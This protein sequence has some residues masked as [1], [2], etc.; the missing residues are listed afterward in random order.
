M[1]QG[2]S[3]MSFYLKWVLIA[4][5]GIGLTACHGGWN[6]QIETVEAI[7]KDKK[8]EEPKPKAVAKDSLQIDS[9]R[10]YE[11]FEGTEAT[12]SFSGRSAF[13]DSK[14][15]MEILNL[16]ERLPGATQEFE[17]GEL[18]IGDVAQE[19]PRTGQITIK[20]TPDDGFVKEQLERRITM[21]VELRATVDGLAIYRTEQEFM[22][23]IR[24]VTE[25]PE[26][27]E[28]KGLEKPLR[29]G[30]ARQFQVVVRD[31][32]SLNG[33]GT[34]VAP[35]LKIIDK[36]NNYRAA[37]HL[38]YKDTSV[39]PEQD[40]QDPSIW[41]IGL[42]VN[43]ENRE[44]VPR[45]AE[46]DFAIQAISQ[47]EQSS[48]RFTGEFE[49]INKI[50]EPSTTWREVIEFEEGKENI[51]T[52]SVFDR[53]NEGQVDVNWL[54][55]CNDLP[56]P[57]VCKCISQSSGK[58]KA[59]TIRW[60]PQNIGASSSFRIAYEGINKSSVQDD[61]DYEKVPWE[62]IIRVKRSAG[63]SNPG[64]APIPPPPPAPIVE[65][66]PE[67]PP[68]PEIDPNTSGDPTPGRF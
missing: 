13:P 67:L 68:A 19:D 28:I 35:E 40:R 50:S 15:E 3:K 32:D 31:P 39:Q 36:S 10:F 41:T 5:T 51:F 57:S 59:C 42:I 14:I 64:P 22:V 26:I 29:E 60:M 46:F 12:I 11:F 58:V 17:K 45:K 7:Q 18:L 43:T 56:G 38:V 63:P 30:E 52:F 24:R 4:F 54:T 20:W 9:A 65:Q 49:V 1:K 53:K 34:G 27:L 55:R 33:T 62:G 44:L 61:D 48:P 16:E 47:F 66:T 8:P 21:R 23:V 2:D 6:E 37:A 25:A